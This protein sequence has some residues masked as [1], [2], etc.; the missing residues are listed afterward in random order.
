MNM[1]PADPLND[2]ERQAAHFE[3]I[4]GNYY[5]SRSNAAHLAFKDVLWRKFFDRNAPVFS[6]C[7]R[8][9]LEP[10]CGYGEGRKIID[11]HLGGLFSYTGFD[12][13]VEMV[14]K[15][16]QNHPAD[17]IFHQD[18]TTYEPHEEYEILVIIGGLHHVYRHTDHV[19]KILSKSTACGGLFI[20]FEPTHNNLVIGKI[21]QHIYNRNSF[22]D[23]E[24]EQG[25][26]LEAL[27]SSFVS[28]GFTLVDQM[29]PGLLAYV[30]YYN[31]DAF[32]R[33]MKGGPGFARFFSTAESF[34]WKSCV[35]KR[36]SFA[37]L[38][39]WRKQ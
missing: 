37:T 31:P 8:K 22:F 3:S 33:L 13:S 16:Q 26:E 20:S 39:L 25:F 35:A 7:K 38:S 29:Y 12:I 23:N 18:V 34:L 2:I 6:G 36:L 27:N 24:T 17:H 28:A 32:P 11:T 10:M 5:A 19:L 14:K 1:H 4:A 9:V 15:A 30:L 21:R